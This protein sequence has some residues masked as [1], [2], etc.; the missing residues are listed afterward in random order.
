MLVLKYLLII[1][2]AALLSGAA[3]ILIYDI[4]ISPRKRNGLAE[5]EGE[6]QAEPEPARP[7]RWKQAARLSAIALLPLLA[8]FSIMVIPSGYAGVRV[9]QISGARPGTLYPGV[10]ALM[11]LVEDVALYS[12][13]DAVYSTGAMAE[14]KKDTTQKDE[15]SKAAEPLHA[16]TSDG[17]SVGFAVTV[18]YRLDPAKLYSVHTTMPA[19]LSAEVVAPVVGSAFREKSTVFSMRELVTSKR[20]ELRLAAAE[21]IGK[22]LGADGIVVKEVLLRD[23]QPPVEYSRGLEALLLKEQEN[24]RLTVELQAKEKEVRIAEMEAESQKVITIKNAEGQAQS[25]VLDS[26]AELERLNRMAEAEENRI[27]RVA[28]ANSEKMK[29][30]AAVLKENPMLIQKI[31]AERLSD[32]VQIMMVPAD[33]KNFFASDVLRGALGPLGR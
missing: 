23:V 26:R 20:E 16:Q 28:G 8:G 4:F 18:R 30:E 31:I 5:G 17:L 25:K 3:G 14:F 6:R 7:V 22:H 10:H 13:R 12:T 33:V 21:S 9:S 2:G 1:V 27:R 24:G 29:L 11:P 32:K 15:A 19:D